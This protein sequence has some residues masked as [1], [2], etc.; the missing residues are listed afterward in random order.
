MGLQDVAQRVGADVC[1]GD[2]ALTSS[3]NVGDDDGCAPCSTFGVQRFEDVEA[4]GDLIAKISTGHFVG[5]AKSLHGRT[6]KIASQ[7]DFAHAV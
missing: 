6:A 2:E 4:H 3:R 1:I 7:G 5:W